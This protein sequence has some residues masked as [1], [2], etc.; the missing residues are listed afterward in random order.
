MCINTDY[1]HSRLC[2]LMLPLFN[3]AIML[4]LIW[5]N[6]PNDF[7]SI[8]SQIYLIYKIDKHYYTFIQSAGI[9]GYAYLLMLPLFNCAIMPYEFW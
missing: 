9:A 7:K 5:N 1:K 3:S 8:A 2:L 4:S 6:L